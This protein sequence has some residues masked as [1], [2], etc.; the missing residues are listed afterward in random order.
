[1]ISNRTRDVFVPDD[2]EA[3]KAIERLRFAGSSRRP[4]G[5]V[6]SGTLLD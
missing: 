3:Q 6:C 5:V 1:M 2:E 4:R